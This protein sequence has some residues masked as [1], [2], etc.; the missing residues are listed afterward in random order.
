MY[1]L[2]PQRVI[3]TE[4]D[5]W[6]RKHPEYFERKR[7]RIDKN[8]VGSVTQIDTQ[9]DKWNLFCKT[10]TDGTVEARKILKQ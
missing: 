7:T 5:N 2:T 4:T 10:T 3:T 8:N 6:R 9:P 1:I